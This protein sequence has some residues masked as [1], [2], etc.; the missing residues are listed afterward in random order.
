MGRHTLLLSPDLNAVD[1]P[2]DLHG[3]MRPAHRQ[4]VVV[5]V[6]SHRRLLVSTP[7]FN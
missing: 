5:G 4:R 3:M 6:E 7:F 2:F 1:K